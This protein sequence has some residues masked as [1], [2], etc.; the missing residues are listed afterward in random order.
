[1]GGVRMKMILRGGGGSSLAS[2]APPPAATLTALQVVIQIL[3]GAK[4]AKDF[5]QVANLPPVALV[6]A[7][8]KEGQVNP[9]PPTFL[10]PI[11]I[12]LRAIGL[13][14]EDLVALGLQDEPVKI[15]SL[16]ALIGLL[17]TVETF[18]GPAQLKMPPVWLADP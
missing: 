11:R 16:D 12:D 1:M 6:M 8:Q 2:L 15:Q 17:E 18:L 9:G 3:K 13:S 4:T 7:Q 10:T 5:T 14:T